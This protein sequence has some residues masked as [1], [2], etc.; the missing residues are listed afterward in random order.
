MA[1]VSSRRTP[2]A[3]SVIINSLH[4]IVLPLAGYL[5]YRLACW[6][7]ERSTHTG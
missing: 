4:L 6:V 7:H 2:G 5:I 3:C 1:A